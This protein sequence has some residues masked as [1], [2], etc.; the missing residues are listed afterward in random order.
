MPRDALRQTIQRAAD[1]D[2]KTAWKFECAEFA[3]ANRL[4]ARKIE[5][6]RIGTMRSVRAPLF[7]WHI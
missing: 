6:E 1:I 2:I 3:D 4:C 5:D 7:A